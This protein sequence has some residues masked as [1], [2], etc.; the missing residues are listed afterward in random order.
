MNKFVLLI[1]SLILFFLLAVPRTFAV[2][3]IGSVTK[4]I[5]GWN[6]FSLPGTPLSEKKDSTAINLI[7]EINR[8][9]GRVTTV[10]R[11]VD[12]KWEEVVKRET[13]ETYGNDFQIESGKSY[14]I[15]NYK[16]VDFK[17]AVATPVTTT[18][19]KLAPGYNFV[20]FPGFNRE[21]FK[22]SNLA[23]EIN[24]SVV[25][26]ETLLASFDSG[27]FRSFLRIGAK[28]Y[29]EDQTINKFSGYVIMIDQ[30]VDF[31]Y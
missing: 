25:Q 23:T 30:P 9:G 27:L 29:G 4:L 7:A 20:G 21:K 24:N 22:L 2:E 13:G 10:A 5:D 8:Q 14:F 28:N 31:A 6:L 15:R 11:F 26:K 3:R 1:A 12:G 16:P 17:L 19:L 18:T